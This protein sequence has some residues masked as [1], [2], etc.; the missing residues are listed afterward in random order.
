[1]LPGL[2]I[3]Q[4]ALG[5]PAIALAR[6]EQRVH[7]PNVR[8]EQVVHEIEPTRFGLRLEPLFGGDVGV[9]HGRDRSTRRYAMAIRTI[10][11]T[12]N[13]TMAAT[14]TMAKNAM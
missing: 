11:T 4:L 1:M 10:C 6:L 13:S 5:I 7:T 8:V 14:P 12:P 2:Q 9:I 3:S